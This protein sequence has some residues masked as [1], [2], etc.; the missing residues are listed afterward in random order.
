M[1]Q[2]TVSP[3]LAEVLPKAL[4]SVEAASKDKF[5][6]AFKSKYADFA[7]VK[8]AIRPIEAHGMWFRQVAH[9][10][11]SGVVVE[12]LYVHPTG[13]LSAGKVFVPVNKR[14]AHGYGSAQTY[15]R[16]YGLQMAFGLSTEDDDGNGAATA[17]NKAHDPIA[18]SPRIN[19]AQF[20]TLTTMIEQSGADARKFCINYKI[21]AVNQL[22]AADYDNAFANLKKKLKAKEA[23]EVSA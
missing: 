20:A 4:A 18:Q 6:P 8:E 22:P 23:S 15:A 2:A 12:T 14:D 9:D 19:E 13:E 21:S 16:R 1:T 11:E 10:H 7:S 3:T 17:L 5:N